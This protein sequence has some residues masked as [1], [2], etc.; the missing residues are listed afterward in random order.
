MHGYVVM[1][2]VMCVIPNCVS[3]L[4]RW[5]QVGRHRQP[6]KQ[7][8]VG[9]GDKLS[10][11]PPTNITSW[12]E[13]VASHSVGAV[14]RPTRVLGPGS[15]D[16]QPPDRQT[17]KSESVR[18]EHR[19]LPR[20]KHGEHR[21]QRELARS[22][23]PPFHSPDLHHP[24]TP[25]IVVTDADF[26]LLNPPFTLVDPIP[27]S[28]PN[29]LILPSLLAPDLPTHQTL[30]PRSLRRVSSCSK[31]RVRLPPLPPNARLCLV[32]QTN[33]HDQSNNCYY[34]CVYSC[35]TCHL[36]IWT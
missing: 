13:V 26:P 8:E 20:P 28:P 2:S 27:S 5:P 18:T 33:M 17:R 34:N 30:F 19:R 21:R 7:R 11:Y 4:N 32:T 29:E 1:F 12:S 10:P 6:M 22:L 9:K 24:A 25:R 16:G 14:H 15:T 36:Y 3:P 35:I 31:C 23:H